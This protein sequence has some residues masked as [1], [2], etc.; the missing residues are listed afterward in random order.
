M[1]NAILFSIFILFMF[2]CNDEPE[3]NNPL[4][5]NGKLTSSTECKSFDGMIRNPIT[6]DTLSCI[7]YEFDGDNNILTL[8][9]IN[10]AFNCCPGLITCN[11][12]SRNDTI[13]IVESEEQSPCDCDCL[14]DLDIEINGITTTQ[15]F[16]QF[17]EPYIRNQEVL[18]F[19]IDLSKNT[20]GE[21]CVKRIKYP[22]GIN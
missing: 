6:P 1:K 22:W 18:D 13:L 9:H 21:H 12:S 5:I 15:Y 14:Y 16:I 10:S 3:V 17:D 20:Q 7:E 2:S 8:K 11:V 19:Q 4:D